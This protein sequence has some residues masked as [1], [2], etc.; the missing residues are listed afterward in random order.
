MT[1]ARIPNPTV[2]EKYTHARI[3][4]SF[5][6]F[7]VVSIATVENVENEPKSPVPNTVIVAGGKSY[8]ISSPKIKDEEIFAVSVPSIC[9]DL[10]F[11]LR[12]HRATDPNPARKTKPV[13]VRN[14]LS[15]KKASNK[16][17][18]NINVTWMPF[19]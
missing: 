2:I 12:I 4:F 3:L 6:N 10:P 9:F 17:T 1:A 8:E 11:V 13:A 19:E 15:C 5:V 18:L 7:S 14:E 16:G